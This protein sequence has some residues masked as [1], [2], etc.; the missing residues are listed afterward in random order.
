M[1]PQLIRRL[2]RG[3]PSFVFLESGPLWT[4]QS[5]TRDGVAH[6][7]GAA[8]R[9]RS[10]RLIPIAT[11]VALLLAFTAGTA[12]ASPAGSVCDQQ[13]GKNI[14]ARA[15]GALTGTEFAERARDLA[16][17]QRDA[18]VSNELLTGNVPS[19]LRHLEA[20]TVRDAGNVI[21]V[22]VLPDY[23]AL[24]TDRDFV[25]VP[26]GLEAA[27]EVA[28][29][30]GFMLPTRRIVNAV[31]AAS[32][33]K[34]DPQPLPAGDQMHS[35][36]Y[37]LRHNEMIRAQRDARGAPLGALTAGDKKDLVLTPRLWKT[38]GRV[39]I[40]G[41]HRATGTPIQPLSTVHGARYADYSHGIRLVSERV[42]VNGVQRSLADVLA[43][44]RL[45]GL[46]SDEGPLP[47]LTER[48]ASLLGGPATEVSA[49]TVAW[50]PR[51]G[52]AR[53]AP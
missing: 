20:V 29:R 52:N 11:V 16:G 13:L 41:W 15:D 12:G 36:A 1:Q 38:P 9:V 26:L 6:D 18:L 28:K 25:F 47:Q 7:L 27:L 4:T 48:L 8:R 50:L 30:F 43:D 21:T 5:Q 33:V 35:T 32:T 49:S 37:L 2:N 53:A 22:C 3:Q 10:I 23:L 17:P 42:Y 39:A 34:L 14:P 45:A 44:P 46:V 40:Y 24:G 19:F 31:Y 51:Q